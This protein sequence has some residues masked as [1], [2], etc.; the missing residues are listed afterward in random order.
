MKQGSCK[1]DVSTATLHKCPNEFPNTGLEVH[2][3][4][5]FCTNCN[6]NTCSAIDSIKK[7]CKSEKHRKGKEDKEK[8]SANL[9]QIQATLEDFVDTYAMEG[10]GAS[11]VMKVCEQT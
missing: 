1:N 2:S 11:N 8:H 4:Q 6:K 10:E 3:G 7:H 5:L 9:A